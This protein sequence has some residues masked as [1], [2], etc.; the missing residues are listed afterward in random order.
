MTDGLR[1]SR[2]EGRYLVRETGTAWEVW[3]LPAGKRFALP[4]E[5]EFDA[6]EAPVFSL[7][8]TWVARIAGQRDAD[9]VDEAKRR[10]EPFENQSP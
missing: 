2:I 4:G 10:L 9:E 1:D 5:P 3:D 7:A 8:G 6:I